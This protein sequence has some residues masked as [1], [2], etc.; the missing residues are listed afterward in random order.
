MLQRFIVEMN[1][2]TKVP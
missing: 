1:L 2:P